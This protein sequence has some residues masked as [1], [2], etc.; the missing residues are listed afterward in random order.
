MSYAGVRLLDRDVVEAAP[1]EEDRALGIVELL[2]DA[3]DHLPARR[4]AD[5][6]RSV[7]LTS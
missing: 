6:V 4:A 3:A 7:V 5:A 2:D 1:L